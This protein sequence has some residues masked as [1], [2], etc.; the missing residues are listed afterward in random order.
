MH[1]IEIN[2]DEYRSIRN[3]SQS[4]F[5]IKEEYPNPK[6]FEIND[7]VWFKMGKSTKVG[8][9]ITHILRGDRIE[10]LKEGYCA[11][12]FRHPKWYESF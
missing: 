9:K 2:S 5:V 8:V 12:A 6:P 7:I 4:I 11:F 10:G 1:T 3:K